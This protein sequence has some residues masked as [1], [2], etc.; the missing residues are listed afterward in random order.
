MKLELLDVGLELVA[1]VAVVE[2]REVW[3]VDRLVL[4]VR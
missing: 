3:L 1:V 4:G 2:P